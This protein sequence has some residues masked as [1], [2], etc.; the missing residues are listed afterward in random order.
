[1]VCMPYFCA[2]KMTM[3]IN[4]DVLA[5]VMKITG[6]RSKTKA[7]EA[8]LTEMVRKHKLKTLGAIGLGMTPEELKNAWEDP[9]PEDTARWS[10]RVAEEAPKDK[11]KHGT[12][13]PRR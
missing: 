8:A 4:E 13:R 7:V 9:F 2:M 6:V 5:E 1:M 10:S 11:V 3:H 12:K